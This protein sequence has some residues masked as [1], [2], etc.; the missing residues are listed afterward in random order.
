MSVTQ[1]YTDDERRHFLRYTRTT[2]WPMLQRFPV[3]D[4]LHTELLAQML[5]TT[6]ETVESLQRSLAAEAEASAAAMMADEEYREAL[7]G[8]P[9]DPGDRIVAVGDSITADR[10]GWFDL[11]AASVRRAGPPAPSL[12]NLGVSGNT[13]ADVLE[14]FDL[15]E[16]AKPTRALLMLGTNDA[17][18]HGR[19]GGFRMITAAETERNLRA[20][21]TL[22]TRDLNATVTV[23]TP[24]AVDQVRADQ[25]FHGAPVRWEATEVAEV[26]EVVR[27]AVPDAV[28]LHSA[29]R[30][31]LGDLLE[32]D[33][34]HPNRSGQ[35]FILRR[36]V[37]HLRLTCGGRP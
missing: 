31:H 2:S 3:R 14:R 8:L 13:T 26:A 15:L 28:D 16:E 6:A 34:V 20:L 9:F 32:P 36:V 1:H 5:T 18:V 35:Q 19:R 33:G 37:D 12:V 30:A 23:I 10:L 4:E 25:F 24:P 22:I 11:L 29:T 17:R 7:T 27:R 21:T